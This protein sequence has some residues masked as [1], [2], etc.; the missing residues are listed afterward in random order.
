M[1][2]K[3]MSDKFTLINDGIYGDEGIQQLNIYNTPIIYI[4]KKNIE[5]ATAY[6]SKLKLYNYN[7]YDQRLLFSY[8]YNLLVNYTIIIDLKNETIE[9][10]D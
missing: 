10:T 2:L 4:S 3:T 8:Q 9:I 7:I 1:I 5:I 6:K